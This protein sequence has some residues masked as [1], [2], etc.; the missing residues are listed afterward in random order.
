MDINKRATLTKGI[1]RYGA[2]DA[3]QC[4]GVECVAVQEVNGVRRSEVARVG[5]LALTFHHSR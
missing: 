5:F 3:A 2:D 4:W 1:F